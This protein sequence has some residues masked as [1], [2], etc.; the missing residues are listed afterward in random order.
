[1][2]GP[3]IEPRI[4]RTI[5]RIVTRSIRMFDPGREVTASFNVLAADSSENMFQNSYILKYGNVLL[6]IFSVRNVAIKYEN[7]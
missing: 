5:V 1:V 6:R 7:T 4:S 2:P 3:R